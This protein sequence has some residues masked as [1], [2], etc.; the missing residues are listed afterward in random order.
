[1][2]LGSTA[3]SHMVRT[4]EY[5]DIGRK[6]YPQY[7]HCAV[8]VAEDITS[9]FLN[10]IALFDGAIPL[11]AVQMQALRVSADEGALVFT[12]VVDELVRGPVDEDEETQEVADRG[13]WDA[14]ASR[15]TRGIL[16]ELYGMVR[17]LDPCLELKYNRF[18]VGFARAGQPHKFVVFWA[19][20]NPLM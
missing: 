18:Y 12:T 9:R 2:Q 11:I 16:D 4:I 8:I 15:P 20:R 7:E 6:G 14:R 3:E 5:W 13:Y 19:G 17:E 10:I 1:V